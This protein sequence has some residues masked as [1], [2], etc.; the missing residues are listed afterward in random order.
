MDIDIKEQKIK[1]LEKQ[2]LKMDQSKYQ[3]E[4]KA[5]ETAEQAKAAQMAAMKDG[6]NIAGAKGSVEYKLQKS[7]MDL[8]KSQMQVEKLQE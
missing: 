2:L 8:K 7:Q 3:V 5:K 1:Q 6:M 4:L